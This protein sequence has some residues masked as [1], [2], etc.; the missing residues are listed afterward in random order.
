MENNTDIGKLLS[1]EI[2]N[3]GIIKY[4]LIKVNKPLML[5]IGSTDQGKSTIIE[6]LLLVCGGK[7]SS[8]ILHH[9]E[10]EGFACWTFENA[11]IRREFY[12]DKNGK[13]KDRPI[14]CVICGK[15]KGANDLKKFINPFMADQDFYIKKS[16]IEKNRFFLDMFDIDLSKLNIQELETKS[17]ASTLRVQ[18]DTYGNIDTKEVEPGESITKLQDQKRVLNH[19]YQ[20]DVKVV[21]KKN[22]EIKKHNDFFVEAD[23]EI[24]GYN[25]AIEEKMAFLEKIKLQIEDTKKAKAKVESWVSKNKIK[26]ILPAIPWPDM[27]AIDEKIRLSIVQDGFYAQYQ[28]RIKKFQEKQDKIQ[29]LDACNKK[30]KEIK[31]AKFR[32]LADANDIC[33]IEGLKFDENGVAKYEGFQLDRLST[34]KQMKLTS[35]LKN[36]YPKGF[37][38]ELV[39]KAESLGFHIGENISKY[40]DRAKKEKRTILATIVGD[41]LAKIPEDVGVYVVKAGTIKES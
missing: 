25:K 10:T 38:V 40:V 16:A 14:K 17:K 39:D 19:K 7:Y 1:I 20:E 12:V 27:T 2:K 37:N 18:I 30:I 22:E 8:D 29:E 31:A 13:I 34:S 41:K 32:K 15:I 4:T 23:K 11:E 28:E 5:F 33:T 35:A 3:I 9:N 21:N 6:T 26:D 36:L 24:E